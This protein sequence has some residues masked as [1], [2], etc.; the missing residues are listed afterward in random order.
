MPVVMDPT[1]RATSPWVYYSTFSSFFLILKSITD[2][3][4]GIYNISSRLIKGI[5]LNPDY[6]FINKH[7]LNLYEYQSQV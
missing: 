3:K 1:D 2:K 6:L 4:Y 7:I 5:F